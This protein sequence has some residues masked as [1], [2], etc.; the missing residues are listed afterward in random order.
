MADYKWQTNAVVRFGD[1]IIAAIVAACGTG[2][3]RT[4]ILLALYKR[5]PVIVITPKNISKQ[6]R[7]DILEIAGKDQKVWLYNAPTEHKDPEAY[8][9]AFLDWLEPEPGELEVTRMRRK[10]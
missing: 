9:S 4:G 8:K 6:W 2:K 5:L 3:T 10:A 1:K 7:D